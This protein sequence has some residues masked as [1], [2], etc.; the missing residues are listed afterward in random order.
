MRTT[1]SVGVDAISDS[2]LASGIRVGKGG[3]LKGEAVVA[4]GRTN[5]RWWYVGTC[6]PDTREVRLRGAAATG[7]VSAR[8]HEVQHAEGYIMWV[9][10]PSRRCNA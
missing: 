2:R 7:H 1:C 6:G 10:Y 4:E 9:L 5:A 8:L 3:G